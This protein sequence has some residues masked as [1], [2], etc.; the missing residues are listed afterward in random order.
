MMQ[1]PMGPRLQG[2]ASLHRC[3]APANSLLGI[4]RGRR[5]DGS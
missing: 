2:L 5:K 3:Q 1:N 4:L